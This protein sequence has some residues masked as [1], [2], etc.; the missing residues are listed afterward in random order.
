M[1]W[2]L[3]LRMTWMMKTALE[4]L[5]SGA[6]FIHLIQCVIGYLRVKMKKKGKYLYIEIMKYKASFELFIDLPFY[7]PSYI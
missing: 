5:L 6:C 1:N 3:M 2:I 7:F 4:I